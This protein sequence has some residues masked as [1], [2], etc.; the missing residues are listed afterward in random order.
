MSRK[1]DR[2]FKLE[3]VRMASEEGVL[4]ERGRA[5]VRVECRY[6]QPL[7]EAV[8]KPGRRGLSRDRPF[9]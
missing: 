9:T 1:Y 6:H 8:E 7:E 5:T 4:G 3:A 2:E